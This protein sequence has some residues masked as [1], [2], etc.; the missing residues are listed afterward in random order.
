MKNNKKVVEALSNLCFLQKGCSIFLNK[1][2]KF[3]YDFNP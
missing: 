1:S 3:F 2:G